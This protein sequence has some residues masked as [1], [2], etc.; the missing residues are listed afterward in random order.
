MNVTKFTSGKNIDSISINSDRNQ[1]T[2]YNNNEVSY[3][4][5]KNYY[6]PDREKEMAIYYNHNNF[7]AEGADYNIELVQKNPNGNTDV[8]S[9]DGHFRRRH[10][11]AIQK[12]E[13]IKEE[14][15]INEIS[16]LKKS[17]INKKSE[18]IV[19]QLK[20]KSVMEQNYQA[21][22]KR[23]NN[24]ISNLSN[25]VF[26]IK[27][28]SQ[29]RRRLISADLKENE[30]KK[31]RNK[32]YEEMKKKRNA[33]SKSSQ[34]SYV[35]NNLN[36]NSY[37]NRSYQSNNTQITKNTKNKMNKTKFEQQGPQQIKIDLFDLE[38]QDDKNTSGFINSS[39]YLNKDNNNFNYNNKNNYNQ[40]NK[41]SNSPQSKP[42]EPFFPTK[43]NGMKT[44]ES[45]KPIVVTEKN[46]NNVKYGTNKNQQKDSYLNNYSKKEVF[47]DRKKTNEKEQKK[48]QI[49]IP[50][51][52][53]NIKVISNNPKFIKTEAP[54]K[55]KVNHLKSNSDIPGLNGKTHV[56]KVSMNNAAYNN[57]TSSEKKTP[58]KV[59]SLNNYAKEKERENECSINL[60]NTLI[61]ES[62]DSEFVNNKVYVAEI[63]LLNDDIN[64]DFDK[65]SIKEDLDRFKHLEENRVVRGLSRELNFNTGGNLQLDKSNPAGSNTYKQ[66]KNSLTD[67]A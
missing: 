31:K 2:K 50:I 12:I 63:D 37:L 57:K 45:S 59:S 22:S 23:G 9:N 15:I 56:K 24:N 53:S 43:S 58:V 19:R 51:N 65:V 62:L 10:L 17:H 41:H 46:I 20:Y 42:N 11:E 61:N 7:R 38:D 14:R 4:S 48:I 29:D 52:Y 66:R 13:K 55:T 26:S 64:M 33:L 6:N 47:L 5:E 35:T 60:T 30:E 28:G 16:E 27:N 54:I 67:L 21:D 34:R 25:N 8:L 1:V 36:D 49:K 44:N 32:F 18:Q 40:E 3:S 39:E